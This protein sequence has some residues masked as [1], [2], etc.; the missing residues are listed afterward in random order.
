MNVSSR[1]NSE[2]E[3]KSPR[4][5]EKARKA[6]VED[7]FGKTVH[8]IHRKGCST[9]HYKGFCFNC[10]RSHVALFVSTQLLQQGSSSAFQFTFAFT[11]SSVP[12]GL[13]KKQQI[14]HESPL[15]QRSSCS[16]PSNGTRTVCWAAW[17]IFT[18]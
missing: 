1:V 12:S 10:W 11:R 14:N 18:M 9:K 4:C 5:E 13:E 7:W 16:K 15:L 6:W 17:L 8:S 3:K 2:K